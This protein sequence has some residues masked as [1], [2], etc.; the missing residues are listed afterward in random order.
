MRQ[1]DRRRWPVLLTYADTLHGHTG[2]IYLATGWERDAVVSTGSYFR[3]T[4]TGEQVGRKRGGRN[5]PTAELIQAG[6]RE[7]R[8]DKVRFVHRRVAA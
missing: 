7:F 5:I 6:Y 1:I 2:A 4:V 8:G 3:H